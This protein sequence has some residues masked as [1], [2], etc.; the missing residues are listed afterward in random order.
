MES[1]RGMTVQR[2]D[3]VIGMGANQ[4][5]PRANLVRAVRRLESTGEVVAVSSLYETAPVGGPPQPNYM[6]AALRLGYEGVPRQLLDALLEIERA[7]GRQRRERW[8]PRV[9]DLDILWIQGVVY[10]EPGL[11]LPHP[12]LRERAFALR[13]LLDVAPEAID[14]RDGTPYRRVLADLGLGGVA[15]LAEHWLQEPG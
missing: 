6:N 7:A 8:G 5:R 3:A 13:P 1:E 10:D 15:R 12:R 4:G 11:S 14:P 2:L 9:L